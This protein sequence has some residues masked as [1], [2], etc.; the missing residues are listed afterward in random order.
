MS[1]NKSELI[2]GDKQIAR[3]LLNSIGK[4][5]ALIL[6]AIVGSMSLIELGGIAVIFPFLQV[7]TQPEIA[8][9]LVAKFG[10]GEHGLTT[11]KQIT[12]A[13]GF[14]QYSSAKTCA[15]Y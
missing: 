2:M 8:E 11:H 14:A 9:K 3:Y 10:L 4:R 6:F 1:N 15:L 5:N 7:V 13:L 12:V